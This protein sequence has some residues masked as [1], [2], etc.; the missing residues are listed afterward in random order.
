MK[1]FDDGHFYLNDNG[2]RYT[3]VTQVIKKYEPKK[4]W[5]AITEAYAKKHKKS[6][7]EVRQMWDEERDKAIKK[8]NDFHLKMET[9]YVDRGEFEI[10]GVKYKVVHSPI[11]DGVKMAIPLK[12]E[13][14]I[15][16]ELIVYSHKYKVSGQADLVEVIDGFINIKDYKTSKEIKKESYKHWRNG[17]EMLEFPLS[18]L[19]N[20]NFNIYSLQ[21]N[22]YMNLL[23]THNPKLKIGKMEIHHIK[24]DEIIVHEIPKMQKESKI[25]LQHHL[26]NSLH[27]HKNF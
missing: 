9:E 5:E 12:L 25:I 1:Y 6:V 8:G 14:G 2:D 16:P 3:S 22:I 26:E 19:M 20:C 13:S 17:Y 24:D 7:A 21:L 27:E 11:I 4:D 18:H 23:K 15:Y 10:N